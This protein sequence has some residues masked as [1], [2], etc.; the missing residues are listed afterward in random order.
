MEGYVWKERGRV[1]CLSTCRKFSLLIP[2]TRERVC[3]C[4]YFSCCVSRARKVH[5]QE[6]SSVLLAC[7]YRCQEALLGAECV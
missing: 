1:Y 4:V 5:C 6:S 3:V 7:V 2:T